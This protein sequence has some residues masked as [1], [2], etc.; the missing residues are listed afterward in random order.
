[1][2]IILELIGIM[3]ITQCCLIIC[4]TFV[5]WV[6]LR[7]FAPNLTNNYEKGNSCEEFELQYLFPPI[8]RFPVRT[9]GNI[10]Y[11][12]FKNIG[13]CEA[14]QRIGGKGGGQSR[15]NDNMLSDNLNELV[16]GLSQQQSMNDDV[17][18]DTDN[19]TKSVISNKYNNDD[20]ND[21]E[22]QKR[23]QAKN[24]IERRLQQIQK[25]Y[26]QRIITKAEKTKDTEF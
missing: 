1:M 6:I 8:L 7:Y 11:A 4:G 23:Q 26:N 14:P 5:A 15:G 9:I 12:I 13:C 22:A 16:L 21:V 2:V 17:E 25:E 24:L 10:T 20:V 18:S 3:G 19:F